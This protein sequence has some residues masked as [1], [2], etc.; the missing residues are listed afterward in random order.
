MLSAL[1]LTVAT[2]ACVVAHPMGADLEARQ[3]GPKATVYSSCKNKGDVALTFDDGPWEYLQVV[4]DTLVKAGAVGT[5]FFNGNNYDCIYNAA[6]QQ[7]VKYAYNAG[8]MIGSHTWAHKD[9]TTLSWDQIH[10]EM[11]RVEQALQRIIGVTPAF[12]RPPYGNYNDLVRQ[13][14]Y[15]RNQSLVIWDFDDGDSTGSSVAQSEADYDKALAKHPNSMLSLNHETYKTTAYQV[16]PYAISKLQAGGYKM[17]SVATCLGLQPYQH[18]GK[19]G[20]PD[21]TWKC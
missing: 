4:S 19:P 6:E 11:W 16:L 17:V 7:R 5:F 14:S 21:A 10:D 3:G 8:H 2:A 9:L 12:M 13:V 1:L 15:A 20:T 18:V